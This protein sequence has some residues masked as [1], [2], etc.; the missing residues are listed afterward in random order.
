MKIFSKKYFLFHNTDQK[1]SDKFGK[2]FNTS[3]LLGW[4][5]INKV[6]PLNSLNKIIRFSNEVML[7]S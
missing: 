5:T 6:Y 4:S 1:L 3:F 2:F 7:L